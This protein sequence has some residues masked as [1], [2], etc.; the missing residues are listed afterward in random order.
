MTYMTMKTPI[1]VKLYRT[2]DQITAILLYASGQTLDSQEW[3][4]GVCFFVFEDQEA[5][6][7]V[8]A[9]HYRGTLNLSSKAFI[10]AFQTIKSILFSR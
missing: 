8:M 3:E 2:K 1:T 7:R 9:E 5:C 10:E 4:D 6:E